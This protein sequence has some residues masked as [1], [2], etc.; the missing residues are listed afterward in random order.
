MMIIGNDILEAAI[1]EIMNMDQLIDW[2]PQS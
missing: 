2:R 1:G